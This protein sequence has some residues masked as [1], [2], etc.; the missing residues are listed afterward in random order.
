[1]DAARAPSEMSVPPTI[2]K[3]SKEL[4]RRKNDGIEWRGEGWAEAGATGAVC[5][6]WTS[7]T[8]PEQRKRPRRNLV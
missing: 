1:M 3:A 6:D 4:L 8:H 7:D 2:R 5:A